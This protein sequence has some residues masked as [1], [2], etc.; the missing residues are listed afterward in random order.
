MLLSGMMH[1]CNLGLVSLL[2]S[3]ACLHHTDPSGVNYQHHRVGLMYGYSIIE[4]PHYGCIR[5]DKWHSAMTHYA[6]LKGL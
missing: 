3:A 4:Q 2:A 1:E 5:D 6:A